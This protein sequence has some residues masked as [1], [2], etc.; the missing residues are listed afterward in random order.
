[1]PDISMCATKSECP[2]KEK[3][4]RYMATATSHYQSYMDFN[5]VDG[6]CP[7]YMPIKE[8]TGGSK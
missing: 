2:L 4:Y 8:T 3:C 6:K 5:Y 1:M 7:D